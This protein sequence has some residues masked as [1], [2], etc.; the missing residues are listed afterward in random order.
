[1]L[2]HGAWLGAWGRRR[3]G[4]L[5]I[6]GS[7]LALS[8]IAIGLAPSPS[9]QA[10][11]GQKWLTSVP[12]AGVLK[13]KTGQC[14]VTVVSEFLAITAKH[15]GRVDP[16]LKL[17][18][19]AASAPGRDHT[20]KSISVNRDLDVEALFLRDRTGLSV[21]PLS[22]SVARDWFYAWGYGADWSNKLTNHLTRAD[23]NLPQLCPD[24]LMADRGRLCW[25]TTAKNS[26]CSGDS[27][28]P[29]TQHGHIIAMITG[30]DATDTRPNGTADCSTVFLGQAL[31]VEQMQPWLDEMIKEANP[32]P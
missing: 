32:F 24:R 14:S 21:T 12:Y 28:G 5:A 16:K 17:D 11:Q 2:G 25:Q 22:R 3:K 10:A 1:M 23:F 4:L 13:T 9:S 7:L 8:W 19:S 6:I 18:V 27:G 15:C 31:P 26:V 29:V 20:V 30:G